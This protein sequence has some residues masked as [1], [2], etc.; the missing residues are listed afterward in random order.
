MIW[1]GKESS[2][3]GE[4][5]NVFELELCTTVERSVYIVLCGVG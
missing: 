5:R 2:A 1:L 4:F 3:Q